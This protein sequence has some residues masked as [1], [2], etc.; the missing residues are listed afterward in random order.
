MTMKLR[1]YLRTL[2]LFLTVLGMFSLAAG[3]SPV[4][5]S[6]LQTIEEEA[7]ANCESLEGVLILPL[8]VQADESAFSGDDNL[9]ILRGVAVVGDDDTPWNGTLNGDV[10]S[11][12]SPFC[13]SRGISCTYT[14]DAASA[15]HAGYNVVIAVGFGAAEA[16]NTLQTAYPDVRFICLDA[17]VENQQG[18]VYAASYRCDQA[19]FMAGYTAVKKGYRS[20]G[21]MGGIDVPDVVNY[22]QGFVRGANQAA[23]EMG[24][25]DEVSVAY[26]YTGVFWPDDSVYQKA[27]AWYDGGVEIIFCAGGDQGSSVNGAAAEKNGIMIGVDT[28]QRSSLSTVL[29]SAVKNLGFT[30]LDAL[31]RILDGN[32]SA[33]GGT[34]PQLGLVSTVPQNNHVALKPAGSWDEAVIAAL[35]N[36]T[37]PSGEIQI[38]V[39]DGPGAGPTIQHVAVVGSESAPSAGT[40][41]LAVKEEVSAFCQAHDIPFTYTDSISAALSQGCD[42]VIP[43]GFGFSEEVS[44]LQYQYDSVRFICLDAAIDYPYSNLYSVTY[45][46]DQAG[47]M[48]GYAAVRMG[49]RSL[50]FMGGF[51]VHEVVQY[52]QGFLQGASQAA[53]EMGIVN[54]VSVVYAY[55]NTFAPDPAVY[56]QA[57]SWYGNGTEIIFCCGGGMGEAVSSVAANLGKKM[58]GVDADQSNL[59]TCVVTSAVKNVAFSAVNALSCILDGGWDGIGGTGSRHGVVSG[60][61]AENHVCLAASTQFNSGFSVSDYTAMIGKLLNGTYLSGGIQ[62]SVT[63]DYQT[64]EKIDVGISLPAE[65]TRW[66]VDG[67]VLA[68]ALTGADFAVDL[69]Y[70]SNSAST[71]ADQIEDMIQAGCRVLIVAPVD[72]ASL[73]GVLAQAGA[74]GIT[75]ISYDRLLTDTENVDYY[76]TFSSYGIGAIQ[77]NY[78][79]Q[80]LGLD[81]PDGPEEP[82]RLELTAGDP[83][84]SNGIDFY[85]GAKDVLSPYLERGV[86]VVPSGQFL[87][88]DVFTAGWQTEKAQSRAE[89]LLD[90]FYPGGGAPDAWLCSNDSTALGVI[91]ALIEKN[92]QGTWPVI[93]GQ[94]CDLQNVRYILDHK[95]AMSVFKDTRILAAKAAEMA[96]QVLNSEPVSINDIE[97]YHNGRK[98]V[99]AFLCNP[100]CV[101]ISNCREV[102]IEAGYY[103]E[104]DFQ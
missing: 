31:N 37:Y 100:S 48:A 25:T 58:I 41:D 2:F 57:V 34:S 72:S 102:L 91:R 61:P 87:L 18:N 22:G 64:P 78:I 40:M 19:G 75:V 30:A 32:W 67:G 36:G 9:Y 43:I 94:D 77:G 3:E 26:T 88:S 8:D 103:S 96:T 63:G 47:F 45:R 65:Y 55:M 71:Q 50:G 80:A 73:Q 101:D 84:D 11:A 46:C 98:T 59:G 99:P 38:S 81:E 6:A 68:G 49:Y 90:N 54:Q 95:Q 7:F 16:V 44:D 29:Y 86:L 74:Q 92:P 66:T 12:V 85:N 70:A 39:N 33:L 52:G 21:Y 20:L 17:S 27:A 79:I 83:G 51:P 89:S 1:R 82:F 93:T 23:V 42:V 60:T 35:M 97:S 56:D 14:T 24:I 13:E 69:Q 53:V 104:E 62:I 4:L 15:I 5:P 10:W 76:V 28:D